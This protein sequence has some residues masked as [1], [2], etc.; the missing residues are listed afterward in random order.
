MSKEE[1]E[2]WDE[3]F[4]LKTH[5]SRDA[6]PLLIRST[7]YWNLLPAKGSAL[8][9]ACGAGRN[10]VWLAE[11]GW[12]VIGCDLSMEGLHRAQT[13]A[14]ERKVSLNLLCADIDR[15]PPL[16][17]PFDLII[18]FFYLNRNMFWWL[19]TALKPGGMIVFKTYTTDQLRFEGG[20][21]NE[22]HL[23]WP[24]E[25]IDAFRGFRILYH[26]ETVADQ[27]IAEIIAQKPGG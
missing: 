25:S 2:A 7:D 20:P 24:Q 23:L 15:M 13:L 12:S 26:E 27:G 8:D 9:V 16:I 6:D 22:K 17:P 19:K 14:S 10:S 11:Q 21:R 4:R 1:R 18:C 5:S 3:R